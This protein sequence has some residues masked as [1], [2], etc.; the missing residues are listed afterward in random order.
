MSES[1]TRGPTWHHPG[2]ATLLLFGGAAALI[3]AAHLATDAILGFHIDELYYLASGRHPAFGYVDFPPVVPLLARLET[4]LL[5]VTPWTLRLL[6]AL[7]SGVNVVISGAY[8]R[9]LGGSL[10][11]QALGLLVAVTAPLIVGTWLFQ[12]V[13]FDQVTWMLSLYWLLSLVIDRRPRTWIW[14]GLTLGVG[15]EV[16]YLI[17]PLIAGIAI[18]VL[19]TPKLRRELRTRPGARGQRRL[20][21]RFRQSGQ[22]R[23][24]HHRRQPA[25]RD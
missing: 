11:L 18:A 24:T 2:R 14:L 17:L 10:K 3:I 15:L 12:T 22:V 5:G 23:P 1:R 4:G 19:L 7:L 16:K 20:P 6:P 8:V 25:S 13:I 21:S 9:K